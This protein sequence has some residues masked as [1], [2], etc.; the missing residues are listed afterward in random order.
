M[1][2]TLITGANKGLGL[3]TARQLGAQGHYI[4]LGCRDSRN[5][6]EAVEQLKKEGLTQLKFIHVD[7]TNQASVDSAA[8]VIAKEQGRLDV[9]V[10]NAG[11]LGKLPEPG[12]VQPVGEIQRIFETNVFGTIRVTQAFMPLLLK[13]AQ[14]RIVNVTS[15]LASLSLHND[16]AWRY[17]P[18]KGIGYGPSKSALNAYTVALA[19]Q[20]RD[21]ACKVNCVTPGHTATDFNQHRGER[22]PVDAVKII[23]D[24][25]NLGPD[26]PNGKFLDEQGEL[27]W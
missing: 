1:K 24:C 18:Y 17:Y 13:A 21:T 14:P 19:Y 8:S 7:V 16:P 3:E 27:P 9:L 15:D 26:G 22:Q 23:V 12:Q 10:N 20:L 25:A 2:I 4:Y 11:I 6:N 5:G